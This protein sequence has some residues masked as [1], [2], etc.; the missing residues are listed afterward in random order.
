VIGLARTGA[1]LM[2]VF[3]GVAAGVMWGITADR[4]LVWNRMSITEYATDFR[5]ALKHVD[6]MMPI[7]VAL[8]GGTTTRR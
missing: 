5:R 4:L 3:G 8:S 6:P 7:F 1:I 2:L